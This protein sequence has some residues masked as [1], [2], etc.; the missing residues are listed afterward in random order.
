MA[1]FKT[2][3]HLKRAESALRAA[4][5]A[6]KA[7]PS[8]ETRRMIVRSHRSYGFV[9]DKDKKPWWDNQYAPFTIHGTDL[10]QDTVYRK[11]RRL[12][13]AE[14]VQLLEDVKTCEARLKGVKQVNAASQETQVS[15][16][17]M[18]FQL[19]EAFV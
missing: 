17:C 16:E 15:I 11:K 8:D 14:Y 6:L 13:W 4:K 10:T 18:L 19:H 2:D 7:F 9:K 3:S 5:A 12:L 1:L